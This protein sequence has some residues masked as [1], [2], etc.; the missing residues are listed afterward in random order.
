LQI[1]REVLLAQWQR[2]AEK[3]GNPRNRVG[4]LV[5]VW[6]DSIGVKPAS[7]RPKRKLWLQFWYLDT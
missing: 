6:R 1:L 3:V 2:I 4:L 5:A 7:E